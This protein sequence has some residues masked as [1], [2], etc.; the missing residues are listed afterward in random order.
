MALTFFWRVWSW[1]SRLLRILYAILSSALSFATMSLFLPLSDD[2]EG[3]PSL[4]ASDFSDLCAFSAYLNYYSSSSN[5]LTRLSLIFTSSFS[6]YTLSSSWKIVSLCL[7]N[8]IFGFNSNDCWEF[9]FRLLP[10]LLWTKLDIFPVL[11]FM[12]ATDWVKWTSS[13]F[14]LLL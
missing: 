14:L 10:G 6:S 1:M 5:L 11:G 9:M 2:L 13:I 8:S 4:I 3:D 12:P 7:A